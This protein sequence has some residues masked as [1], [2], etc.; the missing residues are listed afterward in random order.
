MSRECNSELRN[1]PKIEL[2]A[3]LNG[4]IREKTLFELAEER[5]IEL[6]SRFFETAPSFNGTQN[7]VN[8]NN[9]RPA[10]IYNKRH[11]SLLE[12]FDIFSEIG[13]VIIDLD[14]IRRIT[15]EALED[16]AREGVIYLELRST[17]KRLMAQRR[18]CDEGFS[19]AS[20][21]FDELATKRQYCETVINEIMTFRK[22]DEDRY[23]KEIKDATILAPRLPMIASFIVSVDRSNPVECGF[24]HIDLAIEL[25]KEHP[26]V[27]V[28]VDLGGNPM[29]R[30][31]VDFRDCF[32][33]ARRSGLLSVTLHCGEVPCTDDNR[34]SK[35]YKDALAI[36]DFGPS[37][38]GHALILPP[39]LQQKLAELKIPIETCPTSNVM[40]TELV[41]KSSGGSLVDGVKRHPQL[42][43]WLSNNHPLCIC[44]DD[45]GV[46]DTNATQEFVLL[47]E[48]FGLT[49]RD[50]REIVLNAVD[51]TFADDATKTVLR[52][53]I[54]PIP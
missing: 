22:E 27:V 40:T 14:A 44:T 45:P 52:E 19:L 25:A 39:S 1:L 42:Q 4:S 6:N 16:F 48:A 38:L 30:G 2:H 7:T 35:A 13:K 15:R 10:L 23:S 11:R 41:E 36:L 47:Q 37:R 5:M 46:F 9:E 20:V 34:D 3:H 43:R 29:K 26:G 51:H 21:P 31:F 32:E 17:P 18:F 50:F 49:E 33:K 8:G 24:E 28:G 54:Q 12:C 53:R